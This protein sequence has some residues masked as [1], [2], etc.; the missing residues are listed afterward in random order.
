[1]KRFILSAALMMAALHSHAQFSYVEEEAKKTTDLT[2]T[3]RRFNAPSWHNIRDLV[4]LRTG[5]VFFEIR[6]VNDYNSL[7]GLDTILQHLQD[8][9]TF[10]KDSLENGSANIRIDYGFNLHKEYRELRFIKYGV[11]GQTFVKRNGETERLKIEQDTVRIIVRGIPYPKTM[12]ADT[13]GRGRKKNSNPNSTYAAQIT[14]VLNNYTDISTLIADKEIL[15]H[16]MDTLMSARTKRERENPGRNPSSVIFTPFEMT[17]Q[18]E[19]ARFRKYPIRLGDDR[20]TFWLYQRPHHRFAFYGN[21]GTGTIRN[22]IAPNADAGITYLKHVRGGLHT[23]YYFT[24]LYASA[25]FCFE[26]NEKREYY[27][28]DN[29]FVNIE[30]GSTYDNEILGVQVKSFSVGGGWLAVQR[31]EYFSNTTVKL[32]AGVR[33]LNGLS[34]YPEVV[35]T[36]NFKQIFP[37]ISLKIFGF[38]R[39]S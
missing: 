28:H 26:R 11:R 38:K 8:D 18:S 10:C 19:A 22:T 12:S 21:I 14:L 31:G 17:P 13:S 29:W 9:L 35:A 32:F 36:N 34:L 4:Y 23:E 37:G 15:H 27:T 2:P 33:L 7:M 39:E 24:S 1:M 3:E 5:K 16:I 25:W 30:T 6:D 20:S